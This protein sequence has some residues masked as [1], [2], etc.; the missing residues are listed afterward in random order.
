MAREATGVVVSTIWAMAGSIPWGAQFKA[1]VLGALAGVTKALEE[2]K[3]VANKQK[4]KD[5]FIMVE[6][7][8]WLFPKGKEAKRS[9]KMKAV[10]I[11]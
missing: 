1:V 8:Y 4:R 6:R 11:S 7:V 2:L 5:L 10:M 9:V 3:R